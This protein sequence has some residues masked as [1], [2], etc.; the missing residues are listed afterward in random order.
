MKT[1]VSIHEEQFYINGAPTYAELPNCATHFH[2]LLMNCRFIQG[3][4]DDSAHPEAFAR[5]GHSQWDALQ[6]TEDLIAALPAWYAHGL[7]AF[8]VGLQ[9]GGPCFTMS[10][11]GITCNPYG[12]DGKTLDPAFLLRLERLITAADEIGMVVI[13]SYFYGA[14]AKKIEDDDGIIC[15][16]TN[17]SRWLR[18]KGFTN[19]ILELANENGE[20]NFEV[21]PIIYTDDGMCA[22]MDL[23]RKES[24]GMIVG[25]SNMGVHYSAQIAQHSDCIF[26]HG[27]RLTRGEFYNKIQKAKMISPAR[28]ILCNEDSQAIGNMRVAMHEGVSW[29]YYNNS[30]KQEPPTN[31]EILPGEDR[32]FATRMAMMLGIET[33]PIAPYY[34]QGLEDTT[35][36]NHK[37]WVR[38]ASLHPEQIDY[39]VF[40]RNGRVIYTAYDEPFLVYALSNWRQDGIENL[41][42]PATWSAEIHLTNGTTT[43]IETTI[44]D[45]KE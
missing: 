28:P 44:C 30:T 2:G 43:T 7:R 13:I 12:K 11:D 37:R 38:L 6:N 29:G 4:F 20:G 33:P 25:C 10:N 35:T 42:I 45:T 22:L 9:G 24:G 36:A 23:A 14:Q 31:W 3:I 27:N 21:H 5:F 19:L 18:E 41:S 8:T 32:Y 15:A 40:R 26:I 1:K 34:L 39:V 17:L 16:T